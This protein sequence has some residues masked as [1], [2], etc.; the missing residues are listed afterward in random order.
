MVDGSDTATLTITCSPQIR[1]EQRASLLL[2]DREVLAEAHA[3]Q[4]D[5]LTFI[6]EDAPEG[7]RFIRLRVDGVDSLLVNRSETP[8]IFDSAMEVI[9]S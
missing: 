6:V 3:V 2:G 5:I 8:P 7:S 4:T 9:I 1:P